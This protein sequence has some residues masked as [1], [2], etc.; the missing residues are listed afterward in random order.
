MA[1][2]EAMLRKATGSIPEGRE[3]GREEGTSEDG[4]RVGLDC[5]DTS[6]S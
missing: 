6:S 3:E 4:G 5:D 1:R 2:D